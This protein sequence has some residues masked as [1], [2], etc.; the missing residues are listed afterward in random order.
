[1][2]KNQEEH[3]NHNET[4]TLGFNDTKGVLLGVLGLTSTNHDMLN[5]GGTF[6]NQPASVAAKDEY[7]KR[8]KTKKR[9]RVK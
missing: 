5:L 1:M 7:G 4:K 9:K 2:I 3:E 6:D 8:L